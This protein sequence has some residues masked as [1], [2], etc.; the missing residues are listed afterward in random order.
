MQ[1]FLNEK[2]NSSIYVQNDEQKTNMLH[3]NKWHP[4]SR[5]GH[6]EYGDIYVLVFS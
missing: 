1:K 3:S 6:A 5:Q 4:D 2:T